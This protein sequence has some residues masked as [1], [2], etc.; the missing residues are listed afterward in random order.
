LD[1][2]TTWK[3]LNRQ[4]LRGLRYEVIEIGRSNAV[5]D[6]F[7]YLNTDYQQSSGVIH[8]H[9][10]NFKDV[11]IAFEYDAAKKK[12]FEKC[13]LQYPPEIQK[14]LEKP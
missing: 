5:R 9:F 8:D 3:I 10:R 13:L 14:D 11:Y 2:F 7:H 4:D 1:N 12:E 6:Y